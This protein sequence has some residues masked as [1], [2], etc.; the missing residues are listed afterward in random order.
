MY[1]FGSFLQDLSSKTGIKFELISDDG[2]TIYTSNLNTDDSEKVSFGV[3]IGNTKAMIKMLKEYKS[4]TSLLKY[5]IESKYKELFSMREQ[6]VMDILE[7]KEISSEKIDKNFQFLS[8]GCHLMLV[9]VDGSRYESLNIIR[10]LYNDQNVMSML[11]EDDIIV[12]GSFDDVE[13]H[14][15]SIKETIVSNLY[16]RCYVSYSVLIYDV[17]EI[18]KAYEDAKE[19]ILIG[20]KLGI[21]DE[22]FSY[23]KM[24]FEK[25][26]YNINPKVKQE[27]LTNFK[28]KLNLFDS[29]IINTIEEFV[30]CG[31]N[32]SDA[33]RKLYIHRNT[34]IYRLDKINKETGFDIRNF[35]EAAVFIIAFL[36]WKENNK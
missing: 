3:D 21:K 7:G 2:E 24:L 4:C 26:V 6:S 36:V 8:K 5:T 18:K 23:N 13:E 34:L 11:Y 28:E 22:I 25:I 19:C 35:K 9:S 15:Q 32:I 27:L 14:A 20:K 12:I 30:N 1:N 31:L 33:A 16:C 17:S 10:Q 29:E